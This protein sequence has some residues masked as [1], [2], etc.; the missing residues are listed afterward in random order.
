M[1]PSHHP[2]IALRIAPWVAANHTDNAAGGWGGGAQG[3][4]RPGRGMGRFAAAGHGVARFCGGGVRRGFLVAE[5]G[6]FVW[7]AGG[8]WRGFG[9]RG[10]GARSGFG[11]A[12][13]GAVGALHCWQRVTAQ[14]RLVTM[15]LQ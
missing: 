1:S 13:H 12:G 7:C 10:G 14:A 5:C 6:T 8:V 2:R 3:G 15:L 11:E 9:R 4:S